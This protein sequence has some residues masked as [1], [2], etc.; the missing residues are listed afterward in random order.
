MNINETL[1]REIDE[2]HLFF[3]YDVPI[4]SLHDFL[5]NPEPFPE[6]QEKAINLIKDV[7]KAHRKK[8]LFEYI[9]ELARVEYNSRE[10]APHHRDHVVHAMLSF[11]L[12]IYI[13]DNFF[14]HHSKIHIDQ[15]QW[16]LASLFHDI[17]YPIEVAGR[18]LLKPF[19]DNINK[20]RNSLDLPDTNQIHFKIVPEGLENLTNNK[21]S[22]DLINR[23]LENWEIDI[24]AREV[25]NTMIESGKINHGVISSLA[26]L[27]VIDLIYQKYNP[28]RVY[29]DVIK[30]GVNFNQY[31]FDNDVVPACSAIYIHNLASEYFINKKINRFNAPIAFLLRL[32]DCLQEWER[33]SSK[34]TTGFPSEHFDIKI[35]TSQLILHSSI[36]E[37]K[38]NKIRNEISSTL[39]CPD[40]QIL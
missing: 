34:N 24:D 40:I 19:E 2:R 26:L 27:N 36:S 23:C 33:P 35:N 13:S 8:D 9:S 25:F 22:F 5:R 7:M 10:L 30:D 28:E 6:R 12:G 20:I 32:S 21:N 1:I 11:I 29:S 31:F 15:F 18:Y 3:Q 37:G 4:Q 38:K 17:G 16:K 14:K 39:I